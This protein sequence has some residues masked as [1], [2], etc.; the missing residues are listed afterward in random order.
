MSY[1]LKTKTKS[2][3]YAKIFV[4]ALGILFIDIAIHMYLEFP[5][6]VTYLGNFQFEISNAWYWQVSNDGAFWSLFF[7]IF[8]DHLRYVVVYFITPA[9]FYVIGM[10]LIEIPK[11]QIIIN[12]GIYLA[13]SF[14]FNQILVFTLFEWM[15]IFLFPLINFLILEMIELGH[16]YLSTFRAK[17]VRSPLLFALGVLIVDIGFENLVLFPRSVT[18]LGNLQWTLSNAWFWE[19]TFDGNIFFLLSF[20]ISISFFIYIIIYILCPFL[21]F[22]IG[23][24]LLGNKSKIALKNLLFYGLP[25]VIGINVIGV[26][27]ILPFLVLV[28]PPIITWLIFLPINVIIWQVAFKEAQTVKT[29]TFMF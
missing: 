3:R 24:L 21:L 20:I 29:S 27:F 22:V 8:N 11:K 12:L 28:L 16:W 13:L 1:T 17:K 10:I 18:Y 6:A 14:T 4:F 7:F 23:Q 15:R 2:E 26:F 5:Y 19:F 9:F 25:L